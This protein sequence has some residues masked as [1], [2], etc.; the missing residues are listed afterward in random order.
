MSE[1]LIVERWTKEQR[2][3]LRRQPYNRTVLRAIL[4]HRLTAMDNRKATSN[5]LGAIKR[6]D[7]INPDVAALLM[8]DDDFRRVEAK[9]TAV[10]QI[11]VES[12]PAGRWAVSIPGVAHRTV[13]VLLAHLDL[14][15]WCCAGK[16]RTCSKL[17]PCTPNCGFG[18]VNTPGKVWAFCGLVPG[19][20]EEWLSKAK[21]GK[22][23]WNALLKQTSWQIGEGFKKISSHKECPK[24]GRVKRLKVEADEEDKTARCEICH[25]ELFRVEDNEVLYCRL[26]NERKRLEVERNESGALRD[27]ALAKLELA[28]RKGWKI[29]ELQ[30]RTWASGK[31][32]A[33]G[34]DYRAMRYAVKMFLSHF[35]YVLHEVEEGCPP[36]VPYIL[37]PGGHADFI[38]PP[39]WPMK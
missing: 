33:A 16:G 10:I 19:M 31:L 26:Y 8:L 22:R 2:N 18:Y 25:A 15:P 3:E 28:E 23:P 36:P 39:N 37:G 4:D 24:H 32:Q 35:H 21:P 6:S 20:K 17:D 12:H 7:D 30:R 27:Q 9:A 14:H 13:G 34:L 38:P 11:I 5:Q 1:S 29:S